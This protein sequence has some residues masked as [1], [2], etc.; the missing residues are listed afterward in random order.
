[1]R[2]EYDYKYDS[3][4]DPYT[5]PDST[6]LRNKLN[7]RDSDILNKVERRITEAKLVLLETNQIPKGHFDLNHLQAMHKYLFG[8]IY[9][10]AGEIRSAGFISKGKSIF[11]H[12]D[13]IVPYAQSLFNRMHQENF[14]SMSHEAC[15]KRMAFYLSEVNAIHPFRE[16]NGRTTRLFFES[17][18][19]ANGWNLCISQIPHQIFVEGMIE[20]MSGPLD[21]LENALAQVLTP[22]RSQSNHRLK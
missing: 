14:K 8:D 11:C 7:I 17:F 4:T 18:A 1:M 9:E 6:V 2:D 19:K 12:S 10:W 15:A 16:G 3:I 20:S 21:K 13:F 22:I 5:Y